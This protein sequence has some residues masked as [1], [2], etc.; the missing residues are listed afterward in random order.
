MEWK[1]SEYN[2][3]VNYPDSAIEYTKAKGYTTEL[4]DGLSVGIT[5]KIPLF[6]GD[7]VRWRPAGFWVM[8]ILPE[9][10]IFKTF[11][12]KKAANEFIEKE[13]ENLKNYVADYRRRV[14]HGSVDAAHEE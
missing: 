10:L 5:N 4:M 12:T 8:S 14:N 7:S 6:V 11:K 1:K 2:I 3:K 13:A 9:G